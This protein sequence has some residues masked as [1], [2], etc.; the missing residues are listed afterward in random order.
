[1]GTMSADDPMTDLTGSAQALP[2]KGGLGPW[3]VL[4][5]S[6]WCGLVAGWLEVGTKVLCRS[7]DPTNRLYMMSRHFVWLTPFSNLLLFS[8]IGVLLATATKLC[9]RR[10]GWLIP[11]LICAGAILPALLVAGPQ[12]YPVAWSILALGIASRLIPWMERPATRFLRILIGSFPVLLGSI[13]VLACLVWAGDRL[14]QGR[15]AGRP[16]PHPESPNVLLIV[17]DTVRAD[18]LS[19]HGYLRPTSRTLEWLAQRGIRFDEARA[20]APWTLPSHASLFTGRWPYE[21][22]AKWMTPL[23]A[24]FPTL[25]EYLGSHGY[26]TAGFVGNTLYCSYDTGLDR[27][28]THYEDYVL[29]F[30]SLRPF[31]TALFVDRA[32]AGVASFGLSVH[33][34]LGAAPFRSGLESLVRWLLATGRKDAGSINREFLDWLAQRPEPRRPFFA[35]LNYF[36]AHSPYLP[37]EGTEFRFGVAP[38]TDADF[39]F[40]NELW[41]SVDKLRLTPHYRRLFR[42]SYD[43]CITYLDE[44]LGELFDALQRKG[45]LDRTLVIVTADHGEELGEHALFDHGESLY[46]PEIRVPLV[47]ALPGRSQSPRI[48][49]E[50]ISLRELP[51][52]IVE[53]AGLADGSPFPG[54]SLARLWRD[55]SPAGAP[56]EG[57]PGL[58]LSELSGPNPSIPSQGRSPASRGPL[59][60]LAEGEF[61]YI[62]NEG[63]GS[64]EF[65]N[66]RDD[67]L[68][69]LNRARVEAMRPIL[70]RFRH[71]L[72][73]VRASPDQA[74]R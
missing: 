63:D 36:D 42:D 1:M 18:H 14:K 8:S 19:L 32:W 24:N 2:H 53:L 74:P 31:R 23:I 60:S 48:V 64:E 49:K 5:L 4:T 26:A 34:N 10:G 9:P 22:E 45:L 15:E 3:G 37:P 50:T 28:F 30:A 58:V 55:P 51:A 54:R 66:E 67:P 72:S 35:F 25:A 73:Q 33:R 47:I 71:R 7:I 61:V 56:A 41:T 62:H 69:L 38:Q 16:L 11:R 13:P 21:L 57:Q 27:G 43:N 29:D 6:A 40:L 52:T 44:K 70:Q 20:T 17:L 68:E 46:R 59:V 65:Y 39:I 12:V